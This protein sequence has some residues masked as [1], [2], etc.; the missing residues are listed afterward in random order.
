MVTR[1]G[2]DIGT[3][4]IGWCLY[5]GDS[6]RDIGVRIFSDG[7][8]PKSGASL[9]VDR[10]AA[11]TMRRRRDRY[12]GRR[13]ALFGVL[14][15]HGL[16]PDDDAAAKALEREDPYDL[17]ARALD[18]Q[19]TPHQLG[20]A[21]FHLN[22][23]RGFKSNRKADRKA[24]DKEG[25]KIAG[26]TK[27]LDEALAGRTL[28]QYL[29]ERDRKR[30]R[31]RP[32]DAE[33]DFYPDRKHYEDEFARIWAAQAAHHP[34]LLTD[35]ARD[36]IHRIIFF[37]RPL[38]AQ[39]VGTCTF[40]GVNGVPADEMRLAK[41]HPLFQERRLYEEVNQLRICVAGEADRPLTMDQREALI[42]KLRSAKEVSFASLGKAIKLGEGG[43][44]NKESENR[45]GLLGDEIR[46]V[47][48]HKKCFDSRWAHFSADEQWVILER[49]IEEEKPDVLHRWLIETYALDDAAAEAIAKARLPEGYCRFGI[50]A[51]RA[52]LDQLKADVCTYAQAA[53]RAG[54]HHSDFRTG[55]CFDELPYYGEILAREIAPGKEDY[56]DPFERR[57]GKITNPTVHIGL[58]QLR[59][60]INAIVRA[61]GRPDEIVVE[62]ARELKLNEKQKKDY[63]RQIKDNTDAA[64]KR[65][66]FLE[67]IGQRDSGGNRMLMRLWEDLNAANVLDRRMIVS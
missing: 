35:A 65:G 8:D 24:D 57:W 60:L 58:N 40:A 31:M 26:G 45:K 37:Q 48:G 46:S 22:Q 36:A 39:V 15:K 54:F 27:A 14:V 62:L 44:F 18:E 28:G 56:S 59:K 10:R 50:T 13:S 34:A 43:R 41:A 55:E 29:N 64:K 52:L 42:A 21:L 33:Y 2:L 3:N 53:E 5:D 67:S 61:Y 23:R 7:R 30:V 32:D 4:S 6:I 16:M 20:R 63:N 9:A 66:E 47:L 38:K 49:L 51:T 1:L 19:L 25:G 11:R 17:R 12:I